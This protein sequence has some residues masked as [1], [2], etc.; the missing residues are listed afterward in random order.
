MFFGVFMP[1]FKGLS[2][3]VVKLFMFGGLSVTNY[4]QAENFSRLPLKLQTEVLKKSGFKVIL[5]NLP[6][7]KGHVK[8][9]PLAK[10]L[11]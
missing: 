10:L 9:D 2:I 6:V 1:Q 3:P 7:K 8:K 11:Q 4:Y 5:V